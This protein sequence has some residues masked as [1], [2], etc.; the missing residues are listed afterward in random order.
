MRAEALI[1]GGDIGSGTAIIDA[2]RT[3]QGAGLSAI[4]G[5]TEDEALEELRSERRVGLVF[6]AIAFYDARRWGVIDDKSQGGG[7]ADAVVL[8]FSGTNTIVNTNAFINYNYLS[9]FDV[10][11]NEI[12]FNNPSEGSSAVVGPE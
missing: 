1:H 10:P 8:S 9:Y 11:T 12:E 7:R 3:Y 2:V 4:G 5:V 6:R